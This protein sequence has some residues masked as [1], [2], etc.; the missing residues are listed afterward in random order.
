M[1]VAY[2]DAHRGRFGVEPICRVLSEH[3]VQIAPSTYYAALKCPVSPAELADAYLADAVVSL[4]RA[5]RSVHGVRKC[6]QEMR[7]A[8]H[9]LGRD[10]VAR[11]MRIDVTADVVLSERPAEV[12]DRAVPGHWEPSPRQ[13]RAA[14]LAHPVMVAVLRLILI[15][16]HPE[17]ARERPFSLMPCCEP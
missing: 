10:Q 3:G 12:E 13:A 17:R 6:W 4:F 11:L 2:I 1:I 16:G 9:R 8:G 7:R 5:N 14:L 15:T